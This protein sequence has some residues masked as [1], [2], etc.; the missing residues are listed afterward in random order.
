[1]CEY[2]CTQTFHRGLNKLLSF[3]LMNNKMLVLSG[4]LCIVIKACLH[5]VLNFLVITTYITWHLKA[6]IHNCVFH[7]CLGIASVT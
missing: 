4:E 2:Y 7:Y 5:S 6:D 3:D 1:M